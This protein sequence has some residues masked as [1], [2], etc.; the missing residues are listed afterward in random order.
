MLI[1]RTAHGSH[2]YGLAT[3]SSDRD[4]Y[5]VH[6]RIRTRQTF[7]G[8]DDTLRIGLS[9]WLR[10]CDKGVPQALEAM[11]APPHLAEVDLF[12]AFRRG[13]RANPAHCAQ[14]YARTARTFIE[15][16]RGRT[17]KRIRHGVRILHDLDQILA[18]GRFDPQSF[19][20]TPESDISLYSD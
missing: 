2:L 10:L 19:S 3:P 13:Y 14:T 7:S 12:A 11:F 17:A 6:D 18:T 8:N 4:W 1:L 15:D 16:P 9:A 20:R 5:E